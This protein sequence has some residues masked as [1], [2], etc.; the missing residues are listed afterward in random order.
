MIIN[1]L[2]RV[3]L[4]LNLALII[5]FSET[6]LLASFPS[7]YPFF[8]TFNRFLYSLALLLVFSFFFQFDYLIKL[9]LTVFA[10]I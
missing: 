6:Y 5:T 3:P 2:D 4:S 1:S 9:I 10:R 8:T 7:F